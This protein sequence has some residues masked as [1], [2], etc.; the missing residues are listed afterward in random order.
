MKQ[1]LVFWLL[2]ILGSVSFF[3]AFWLPLLALMSPAAAAA[4]FVIEDGVRISSVSPQSGDLVLIKGVHREQ[5]AFKSGV[6]YEGLEGAII[7]GSD[8]VIGWEAIGDGRFVKRNW[9]VNS[10]QV[11]VDGKPLRQIGG[12]IP[13]WNS[14]GGPWSAP[15]NIKN[16]W[17]GRI[18]GTTSSMQVGDFYYDSANRALYIKPAGGIEGKVIEVS[19]RGYW[20]SGDNVDGWKAIGISFRHA[21]LSATGRGASL[22]C[23]GCDDVVVKGNDFQ[24][25]DVTAIVLRG[26]NNIIRDNRIWHSGQIAIAGDGNNLHILNNDIR[27]CNTRGFEREWEAACIKLIGAGGLRGARIVGN[28]IAHCNASGIWLDGAAGSQFDN[29]LTDNYVWDTWRAFFIELTSRNTLERNYAWG[30]TQYGIYITGGGNKVQHNLVIGN[31]QRGIVSIYD[32][33]SA[34]KTDHLP[35]GNVVEKNVVGWHPSHQLTLP[36]PNYSNT[37]ESNLYLDN[38]FGSVARWAHQTGPT[39]ATL[40]AWQSAS[41]KDRQS[42]AKVMAMPAEIVSAI[43]SKSAAPNWSALESAAREMDS[44]DPPGPWAAEA[45]PPPPPPPPPPDEEDSDAE[46]LAR[47]EAELVIERARLTSALATSVKLQEDSAGLSAEIAL[48]TERIGILEDALRCLAGV[49]TC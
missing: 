25:P 4:T 2:A 9:S 36:A 31:A 5:I 3:L 42:F 24:Y 37:S 7:K 20:A 6:I 46:K 34:S 41:G 17:P 10:Q 32:S 40:S 13:G 43:N 21:N 29:L 27:H 45:P 44:A 18:A 39:S 49:T 30:N 48:I 12:T 11:F 35:Q 16:T 8:I 28:K 14:T 26:N 22:R 15:G 33:R 47:L 23:V 38:S 1:R 19:V